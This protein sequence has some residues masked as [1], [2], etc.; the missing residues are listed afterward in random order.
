[1]KKLKQSWTDLL[2][3]KQSGAPSAPEE[4]GDQVR[5]RF[6]GFSPT[7]HGQTDPQT[8]GC[9]C[10]QKSLVFGKLLGK[11]LNLNPNHF[12]FLL[13]TTSSSDFRV[14]FSGQNHDGL[15]IVCPFCLSSRFDFRCERVLREEFLFARVAKSKRLERQK[16]QTINN[17]S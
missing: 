12:V 5:R 17:P 9:P 2:S 1:M 8:L 11:R 10:R 4:L 16:G 7:K 6:P 14:C 15:L 3:K 13:S